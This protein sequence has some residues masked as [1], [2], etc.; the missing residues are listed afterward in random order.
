MTMFDEFFRE[1]D[2]GWDPVDDEKTRLH[3]IGS[4]ALM[5]QTGYERGTKDSDV[6][7]TRDLSKKTKEQLLELAG[8]G[9]DIHE[10]RRLYID[11][12]SSAIPFLP[13]QPEWIPL[14]D[15]SETLHHFDLSVLSVVDVVVSKLKRFNTKDLQDIEAMI[16]LGLVD[17]VALVERFELAVDMFSGDARAEDLPK[18]VANLNRIERDMLFVAE[19]GVELPGWI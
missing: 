14:A 11:V 13:Q 4:T 3:I 10:R 18:Y 6:L 1:L 9:T 17:H 2:N 5:L 7:K 19:T 16:D 15:L 12:V 8:R